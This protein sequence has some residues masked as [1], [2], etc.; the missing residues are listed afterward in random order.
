MPFYHTF[1][2]ATVSSSNNRS[3]PPV[4][5]QPPVRQAPFSSSSNYDGSSLSS[6]YGYLEPN[7]PPKVPDS[8]PS[9]TSPRAPPV[10]SGPSVPRESPPV[11][12]YPSQ[13]PA[14]ESWIDRVRTRRKARKERRKGKRHER[15]ERRQK[16]RANHQSV[17]D[18]LK[19]GYHDGLKEGTYIGE[20]IKGQHHGH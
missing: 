18:I 3:V 2:P 1:P 20:K 13:P 5:T 12:W 4:Y 19:E 8:H 11:V 9:R 6:T 7:N 15:Q 17:T 16:R 14:S 10:S